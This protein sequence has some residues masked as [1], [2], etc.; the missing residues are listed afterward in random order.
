MVLFVLP[1]TS[2]SQTDGPTAKP[3]KIEAVNKVDPKGQEN[4]G[5]PLKIPSVVGDR[6]EINL[7]VSPSRK[8]VKMYPGPGTGP[9][10]L[11]NEN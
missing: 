1:M 6:P 5:T 4:K 7:D 3:L 10:G 8:P 9:S 2:W 11:R